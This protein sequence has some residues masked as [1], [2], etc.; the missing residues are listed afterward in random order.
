MSPTGKRM[1]R[2]A[3][4]LAVG[5]A[6]LL[7]PAILVGQITDYGCIGRELSK[8]QGAFQRDRE[9]TSQIEQTAQ[10]MVA[11]QQLVDELI[12]G[13]ATLAETA[14][15]FGRLCEES[16]G[17][18][19][20]GVQTFLGGDSDRERWCKCVLE[21]VRMRL[22]DRTDAADAVIGRLEGELQ[23]LAVDLPPRPRTD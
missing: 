20:R 4:F 10:R 22:R 13:R 21:W 23:A 1:F 16:P 18:P 7:A 11:H 19:L 14:E 2:A 15:R 9:L 12:A 6:M 5:A 3:K 17:F 8:L